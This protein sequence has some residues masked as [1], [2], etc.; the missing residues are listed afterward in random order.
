MTRCVRAHFA[1][2]ATGVADT[3]AV[4]PTR[5]RRR[6]FGARSRKRVPSSILIAAPRSRRRQRI[7]NSARTLGHVQAQPAR[8][9]RR[10]GLL[11][12]A[13]PPLPRVDTDATI[14]CVTRLAGHVPSS[15]P[16]DGFVTSRRHGESGGSLKSTRQTRYSGGP[17]CDDVTEKRILVIADGPLERRPVRRTARG[18]GGPAARR[19]FR[20]RLCAFARLAIRRR[21]A[22]RGRIRLVSPSFS[23]PC[24]H[25][26]IETRLVIAARESGGTL[27][28]PSRVADKL[29]RLPYLRARS[30]PSP[31][32][33]ADPVRRSGSKVST[34]IPAR[35]RPLVEQ[36]AVLHFA[37][38]A[39][40]RKDSP[41]NPRSISPNTRPR[42]VCRRSRLTA[43]EIARP[44]CA[45]TSWCCPA[46][47]PVTAR[48]ARR[49]RTWSHLRVSSPM[50]LTR[51][52]P[53]CGPSKM[54]R[55]PAS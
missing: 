13:M 55:R 40:S 26:T 25:R 33:W 44:A 24:T 16:G 22:S 32:A 27:R 41:N 45:Q 34:P 21:G 11:S 23:D 50:A 18:R 30:A 53:R 17:C 31:E 46:A 15:R 28:G 2:A 14:D 8:R 35:A 5:R 43:S 47:P 10:A 29:T 20:T 9:H 42:D 4:T 7:R 6:D 54:R 36:L 12:S 3:E 52:W 1:T 37:T 19:S 38:H 39:V 48:T 51:W 49:R